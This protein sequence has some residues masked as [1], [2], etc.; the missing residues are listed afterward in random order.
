[1]TKKRLNR[2][3]R[4]ICV[5]SKRQLYDF[6]NQTHRLLLLFCSDYRKGMMESQN[7]EYHSVSKRSEAV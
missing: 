2:Q 5:L 6:L 7:N 4:Y 1:M 3:H